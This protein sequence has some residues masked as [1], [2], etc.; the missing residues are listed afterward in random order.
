MYAD[1]E[2]N[3]VTESNA[4]SYKIELCH[5]SCGLYIFEQFD[6]EYPESVILI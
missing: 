6:F 5:M 4:E 2:K 1:I 3:N